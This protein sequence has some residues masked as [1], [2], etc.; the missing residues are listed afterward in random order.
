MNLK[1]K[2]KITSDTTSFSLYANSNSNKSCEVK[3]MIAISKN[4][5]PPLQKFT[6]PFPSSP[7]SKKILQTPLSVKS[8]KSIYLPPLARAG[9][10]NYDC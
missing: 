5:G 1:H 4:P 8:L 7:P 2:W 3:F 9:G 10:K 6:T